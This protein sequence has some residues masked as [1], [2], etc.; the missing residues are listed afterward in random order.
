M[1]CLKQESWNRL[2]CRSRHCLRTAWDVLINNVTAFL[3]GIEQMHLFIQE[4]G[5]SPYCEQSPRLDV[6][7]QKSH[8]SPLCPSLRQTYSLAQ[9]VITRYG[10]YLQLI[11]YPPTS[12]PSCVTFLHQRGGQGRK[13]PGEPTCHGGRGPKGPSSTVLCCGGLYRDSMAHRLQSQVT[14]VPSDS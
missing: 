13:K 2:A 9:G 12:L 3:I 8:L 6:M 10:S 5:L 4:H 1:A 14:A 11:C 7:R